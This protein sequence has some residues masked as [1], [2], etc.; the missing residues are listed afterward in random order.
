MTSLAAQLA[1]NSSLNS[2][3]LVDRSRRKPKESYLFTGKEA[4]NHDLDSLHAL[5]INGLVQLSTLNPSFRAFEGDL[6]SDQARSTDRTLLSSQLNAELNKSI[7][8]LLP[9]LGPYLLEA[10]TNKVLEWLVRRFRINEF[11]V[12]DVLALF[13]PYHETP[14]FTKMLTILHIKPNSTW[15]FLLP[16]KA[17]A[18]SVPRSPMVTEMLR[19]TDVIRFVA[20]LLPSA[21]KMNRVHRVLLMFNA[22]CLYDFIT[23]SKSLDEGTVSFL[24]PA[25]LEP[26]LSANHDL[27]TDSI[28]GTYVL[29][30]AFSQKCHISALAMKTITGAMSRAAP[31]VS[32]RQFLTAI[33]AVCEPQEEQEEFSGKA[34]K[35][36]LEL[37]SINTEL[38]NTTKL[39]GFDKLM[40]PLLKGLA[41]RIEDDGVQSLMSSLL[42]HQD[43][44]TNVLERITGLVLEG[45]LSSGTSQTELRP[46]LLSIHQR[47]PA[48]LHSVS[49]E[50]VRN[51]DST[52]S[53]MQQLLVS[54]SLDAQFPIAKKDSSQKHD[55]VVASAN[56]DSSVRVTA[57]KELLLQL[58]SPTSLAESELESV[59]TALTSRAQDTDP[60][61]L[62]A[63]YDKPGIITPLLLKSA[64][65]FIESLA[66]SL[67]S[68]ASKPKR[69]I[70]KIHMTFLA[71]HFCNQASKEVVSEVF[72]KLL[73]PFLLFSK[74]RQHTAETMWDIIKEN[75]L[76]SDAST[77]E[78][79][80]GCAALVSEEKAK[81]E[82]G[83]QMMS[84]TNLGIA[85]KIAR[86]VLMSNEYKTHLELLVA[87]LHDENPHVQVLAHLIMRALINQLSGEHQ[88]DAAYKALEA[89]SHEQTSNIQGLPETADELLRGLDGEDLARHTA[90][91]PSSKNTLH[92]LQLAI[93]VTV[94]T[95][96]APT[97]T[98]DWMADL[99]ITSMD[100]RGRRYVELM[101]LVYYIASSP[102]SPVLS[103]S[104]LHVLFINLKDEALGFL[105]GIWSGADKNSRDDEYIR[106]VALQHASAF[107]Q[108]HIDE[109]D[110]IDFQTVMPMLLVALSNPSIS[111]RQAALECITRLRT[112]TE[113]Q[114]VTVYKFDA[115]YGANGRKLQYL[116][117]ND[118]KK[119]L[120]GLNEEVDHLMHDNSFVRL[121]HERHLKRTKSDKRKE[122]EYKRRVLC[123]LLSH[124]QALS[125][126]TAQVALL[127]IIENISDKAKAQILSPVIKELISKELPSQGSI[128]E[129]LTGLCISSFDSSAAGELNEAQG[130][131]W[132]LYVSMIRRVFTLEA[133]PQFRAILSTGLEKGI[134]AD[135]NQERKISLCELILEI[136]MQEHEMY[137]QC[138]KLLSNLLNDIPLILHLLSL[139]QPTSVDPG[140]RASKR[141]K[142]T[143]DADG[144]LG[145][146]TLLIEVLANNPIPC[147]LDLVTQLLDM[148]SRF[149]QSVSPAQADISYIEQ[150][151]MSAIDNTADKLTQQS[152]V[153]SNA[154]RLDVLVELI[155]VSDNPQTFHQ[156]LLLISKLSRLAP[157]SALHNVMPVFTFMGSNVFHRDDTYSFKV[158]QQTI[159]SI[160][161]VMVSSLKHTHTNKL[162]L[163]IASKDFLRV[164]TDASNHIPRHRRNNF[165]SHLVDILGASDFLAPFCMLIVGKLANRVVRQTPEEVQTTLALPISIHQHCQPS[166]QI[167][168]LT[169]VLCESQ[170]LSNLISNPSVAQLAVLDDLIDDESS[171]TMILKRRAKALISFVGVAITS[172]SSSFSHIPSDEISMLTSTLFSLASLRNGVN[173]DENVDDIRQA[174][175][176]TISST[177]TVIPAASFVASVLTMVE[178]HDCNVQRGALDLLGERLPLVADNIRQEVSPT[179]KKITN[180]ICEFIASPHDD[181]VVQSAFRALR[182]IGLSLQ[183]GEESAVIDV[184]PSVLSTIKQ[185]TSVASVALASLVPLS[186]KLGPRFIP[187]MRET[188]MMCAD[189]I[190]TGPSGDA[191]AILRGL[192]KSIPTFW[193]AKE[194]AQVISTYTKHWASVTPGPSQAMSSLIKAVA[195]HTPTKALLS[196]M[197]EMWPTYKDTPGKREIG[198]YF[199][200]MVRALRGAERPLILELLRQLVNVFLES[201]DIVA[202]ESIVVIEDN[203]ISAFK[204]LV[205]KLNEAA[206]K[207]IYRRIYDWAYASEIVD[208]R[209]KVTFQRLYASLLDYFKTLMTPYMSFLLQPV[210]QDLQAFSKVKLQD[211]EY[212]IAILEVLGKSL[213]YDDGAYWRNDKLHQLSKQLIAQVAVC[214]DASF[215]DQRQLLQ[216]SLNALVDTVT[217]DTLLKSINLDLLMHT[218]SE[219][220]GLRMYALSCSEML[221]RNHGG[222]L[223]GFVAETATFIAECNEDEN[224]TVVKESLRLKNTVE[225]VAGSIRDL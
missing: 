143:D 36:I 124:I 99:D 100:M 14:H 174:A 46:L 61:V 102:S 163:Y 18:Q 168:S 217:D 137:G 115:I 202:A 49:E 65:T 190:S 3:L 158:V 181:V 7:A 16:F 116:D 152:N 64:E 119:Y 224:D 23:R 25:L 214:V 22:A 27:L 182:A 223:L 82:E 106:T 122:Y 148:S 19:N 166:L 28:L 118:F 93:V 162:D 55:M 189:I 183:S 86:N 31:H 191:H 15:S 53:S 54:L 72:H 69:N 95:I 195:K 200:V 169:E 170:R 13:L 139:L 87:K 197:I 185:K 85:S 173:S 134:F 51:S 147:S 108:A 70:L 97:I 50:M 58:S 160:V 5:G 198:A 111:M 179:V 66:H 20:S 52:Q 44:P 6:F 76:D 4:D 32:T 146:L 209:K 40:S 141:P 112:L 208:V 219:D 17:A 37:S 43:T 127:R 216:D 201:F 187:Y 35:F 10:P 142:T 205:I 225:G 68:P 29:L 156:A 196:S 153:T 207:P 125:L 133:S 151:L 60:Q 136:A 96:S 45:A 130:T 41:K 120:T 26:L 38:Q 21:I 132:S 89:I 159:E 90:V 204:Q 121:F 129:S 140:V 145:R 135:L 167:N 128:Q 2:A 178:I 103:T 117:Q 220:A 98:L 104:L 154:I 150:L 57:V 180:W 110:G 105:A 67:C 34:S 92:W 48:V 222:K 199:D 194:L 11:N 206:F 73:F 165:F 78:L 30:A 81:N 113:R 83:I 164:F 77:H 161:P 175:Y 193:G 131:L 91:K 221:W 172:T 94:P 184:V 71:K 149:T 157:E 63:L 8:G 212:W 59:Q 144:A 210:I 84:R 39:V 9:L 211:K 107:L 188:V 12:E 171:K 75:M 186:T 126:P 192:L 155:R 109:N 123:Y 203:V 215:S 218:R 101:R 79:L 33:I 62:D 47:H 177:L 88:I 213:S 24:L 138:K 56:A 42:V 1:Q 80:Y 176:S 74:P 114:L